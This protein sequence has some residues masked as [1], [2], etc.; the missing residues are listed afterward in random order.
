VVSHECIHTFT[1]QSN[2]DSTQSVLPLSRLGC[3]CAECTPFRWRSDVQYDGGRPGNS[4]DY[5][6]STPGRERQGLTRIRLSIDSR[7]L[8]YVGARMRHRS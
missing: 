5:A 4:G 6:T 1:T 2:G 3:F 7:W 8:Q